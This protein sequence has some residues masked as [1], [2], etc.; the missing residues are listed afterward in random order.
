[1]G[2]REAIPSCILEDLDREGLF[3]DPTRGVQVN[4]KRLIQLTD[5]DR[6]VK[7][8][9]VLF[10][11]RLASLLPRSPEKDEE[12]MCTAQKVATD[13]FTDDGVLNARGLVQGAI[14]EEILSLEGFGAG[15][16]LSV[17]SRPSLF[18]EAEPLCLPIPIT[19]TSGRALPREFAFLAV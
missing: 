17:S 5:K 1:M 14:L 13:T 9:A 2:L 19:Q 15:M 8:P 3:V 18:G 4:E 12:P 10:K 11:P 7:I 6:L 16:T